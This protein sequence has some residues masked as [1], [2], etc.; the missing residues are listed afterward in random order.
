[1]RD[2]LRLAVAQPRS[3]LRALRP[4]IVQ[5]YSR[6]SADYLRGRS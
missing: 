6:I 4:E 3:Y 1:M 5:S 2:S